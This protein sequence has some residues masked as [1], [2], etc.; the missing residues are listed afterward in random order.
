M[1]MEIITELISTVGFPIFVSIYLLIYMK[2][3]TQQTREILI[4]LESTINKLC[5]LVNNGKKEV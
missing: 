2:R 4:K 3:E 1:E 5:L